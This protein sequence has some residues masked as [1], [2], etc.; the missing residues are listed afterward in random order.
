MATAI[1]AGPPL[2]NAPRP[3]AGAGRAKSK[4]THCP[5]SAE[6]HDPQSVN[7]E[8]RIWIGEIEVIEI[9]QL[10]WAEHIQANGVL[11]GLSAARTPK[12]TTELP[13]LYLVKRGAQSGRKWGRREAGA[14]LILVFPHGPSS[15]CQPIRAC[16]K[17]PSPIHESTG[18]RA[19]VLTRCFEGVPTALS[20]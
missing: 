12:H 2:Y 11:G 19:G 16:A 4:L 1:P 8:S 9:V 14:S 20:S 13:T 3:S 18:S 10:L 17:V 15:L 5:Q 7:A 6:D